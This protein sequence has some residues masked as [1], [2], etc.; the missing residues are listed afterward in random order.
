M[1]RSLFFLLLFAAI[2][3]TV[4]AQAQNYRTFEWDLLQVGYASPLRDGIK[5][6]LTLGT[7]FRYNLT[8]RFSAGFNPEIAVF[9]AEDAG[10]NTIDFGIAGSYTLTGDYYFSD[11]ESIRPFVGTGLGLYTGG[12]A[13]ITDTDSDNP[14]VRKISGGRAFGVSPHVGVELGHL[15]VQLEYSLTIGNGVPNYFG[16]TVAPTLFGGRK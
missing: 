1:L 13:T 10:N 12:S 8:D 15:R 5:P 9:S 2:G 14:E 7:E 3:T 4:H 6:G 16:I 11:T